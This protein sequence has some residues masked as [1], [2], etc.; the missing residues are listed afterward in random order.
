MDKNTRII[1]TGG[2][3]FIG[4]AVVWKLNQMGC[5]NIIIV[6]RLGTNPE[7]WKNLVSLKF[8]EYIDAKEFRERILGNLKFLGGY[9]V[10]FHLGACSSTTEKDASYLIDNNTDFTWELAYQAIHNKVKFVYASS[11][12]TYGNDAFDTS[13]DRS[14][15]EGLKPL[16][17]YGYSKHLFDLYATRNGMLDQITG[18]KYFNIFGPNEYHKG[19]MRS[20]I[21]KSFDE[22][23]RSGK[24][25][26]FK[27][28]LP[29]FKDGDQARD[30]L[31]V[32]DAAEITIFL[33]KASSCGIFNVGSGQPQTFNSL[34]K[35]LFKSIQEE[36]SI[37]YI[38]MPTQLK[39]K[40]QHNTKA[41]IFELKNC[42]Y[43]KPI[44]SFE[45]AIDDYVKNYLIPNKRLGE[46]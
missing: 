42:G 33:A 26:L 36:E 7:K 19:D 11:A 17:M 34:A 25:D 45:D 9:D 5:E 20:V 12:A 44:T 15:L 6:D 10:V 31:Y 14:F 8:K 46:K 24:I 3:G 1:V 23:K 30:F 18:L 41:N 29:D 28:D 35:N 2:A 16:N 38:D 43:S 40:Y 32:K 27:S 13:D 39:G 4:S 22:V 37:N 21:A